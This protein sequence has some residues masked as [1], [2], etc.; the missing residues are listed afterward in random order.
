MAVD[1]FPLSLL[2]A[3]PGLLCSE[4]Q[5][6]ASTGK[7][8]QRDLFHHPLIE[9]LS[10]EEMG[11]CPLLRAILCND[12]PETGVGDAVPLFTCHG[13]AD[14][15]IE[16][17]LGL[18]QGMRN[19]G[20]VEGEG[21][22]THHQGKSQGRHHHPPGGHAHASQGGEFAVSRELAVGEQ[23]GHQRG[24]RERE[25]Q[26]GGQL[27][28]QHAGGHIQGQTGFGDPAHQLEHGAHR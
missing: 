27:E 4:H 5:P 7:I 15:P 24:H 17:G 9:A 14:R 3:P 6:L 11:E 12:L 18:H 21:E 22:Q 23:G 20:L 25:H 28:Q 13:P 8:E 2:L 1:E 19:Q 26:E 10:I 16:G